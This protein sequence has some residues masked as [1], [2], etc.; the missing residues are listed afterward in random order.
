MTDQPG[1]DTQQPRPAL[2]FREAR[3]AGLLTYPAPPADPGDAPAG[4]RPL[5]TLDEYLASARRLTPDTLSKSLA[6]MYAVRDEQATAIQAV[7]ADRDALQA[8]IEAADSV[9]IDTREV[10]WRPAPDGQWQHPIYGTFPL[11][12]IHD[13][14]GQTRAAWLIYHAPDDDQADEQDPTVAERDRLRDE[15]ARTCEQLHAAR[16]ELAHVGLVLTDWRASF[17]GE[18]THEADRVLADLI[19]GGLVPTAEQPMPPVAAVLGS[20]PARAQ[21]DLPAVV[22]NAISRALQDLWPI[23]VPLPVVRERCTAAVLKALDGEAD[24]ATTEG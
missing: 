15:L 9:R 11:D 24:P 3:E 2:T 23:S 22:F 19:D 4:A 16:A 8:A 17:T 5:P 1:T 14:Y 12:H 7:T 13:T 18:P 20:P 6:V 10:I 21:D